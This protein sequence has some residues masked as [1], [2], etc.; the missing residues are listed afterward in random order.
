MVNTK[1]DKNTKGEITTQTKQRKQ[2]INTK[3]DKNSI[4]TCTNKQR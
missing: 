4:N 1:Q 3:Q 2:M